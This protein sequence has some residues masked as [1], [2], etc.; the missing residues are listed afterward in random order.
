MKLRSWDRFR[1]RSFAVMPDLMGASTSF[2]YEGATVKIKL[3]SIDEMGEKSDE[4]RK[5]EFNTWNSK[6]GE[7]IY[8]VI[9]LVDVL[10]DDVQDIELPSEILNRHPKAIDLVNKDQ[11]RELDSAV[12]RCGVK[13]EAAFNY[14][15]S[16][17]RWVSDAHRIGRYARVDNSSGWS[18]NLIDQVSERRVWLGTVCFAVEPETPITKEAWLR[19]CELAF[20][21]ISPP[22]YSELYHDALDCIDAGDYRRALIDLSVSCE[23]FLRSC[24]LDTLPSDLSESARNLI[25]LANVSQYFSHLFPELLTD[26]QKRVFK[27]D[28][29]DELRSLFSKRNDL[30]HAASVEAATLANCKR[31]ALVVRKLLH[32]TPDRLQSICA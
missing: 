3:P 9:R 23:V 25:E 12:T 31:F 2:E 19:V 29:K 4:F 5:A 16:L 30:M 10:V 15:I 17:L 22:I 7:P 28:I 14:W 18:T 20:R 27:E 8:Y 11:E 21:G 32:L 24:V 13:A 26:D 1:T 6:T